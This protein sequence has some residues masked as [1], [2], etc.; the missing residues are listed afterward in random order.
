MKE[1]IKKADILLEALPYIKKFW[2]RTFVIK[3]GGSAMVT[4]NLRSNFAR[5]IIL[6]RYIGIKPVIVH[7]GGPQIGQTL[8]RMGKETKFV[9]GH[10]VTDE[11]TMDIV[12]M[13]LGGKVNKEI[14]GLI[15]K[16]GGKAVGLT[17]KDGG[18]F[19]AEKLLLED[20]SEGK[21]PPEIIDPGRVG[22][23]TNVHPEIIQRMDEGNFIPVIAPV[24]VDREGNTFN[25][26]AD[27]VAGNL[28][29]ALK[30]EKLL[31]MTDVP[32]ISDQNGELVS[33]LDR[34]TLM[35]L[36]GNG[37][38][39]GGMIPKVEAASSALFAGVS[40]VHIIDGRVDHAV[41]LEIFTQT[42]IGTEIL[43]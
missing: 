38:V 43:P 4:E 19:F 31:L 24:G 16:H 11:E 14:V 7:G 30:A 22:R 36:V 23:I 34:E 25:I 28:A 33:S 27:S 18:L 1:L 26:N 17:G 10:R 29:A 6:L 39:H 5:D 8:T 20:T 41:L 37:V 21:G 42:G 40:K 35:E 32:G 9:R 2:G 13:V 15:Q 12:E 3:Y